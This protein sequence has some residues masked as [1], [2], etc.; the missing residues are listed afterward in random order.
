MITLTVGAGLP[1]FGAAMVSLISM[2]SPSCL[3]HA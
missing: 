2:L 1:T 3:R